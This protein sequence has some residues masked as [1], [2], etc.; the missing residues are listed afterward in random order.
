MCGIAGQ[1]A[2]EADRCVDDELVRR[3]VG[4]LVHRGPDGGGLFVD[5]D[6]RVAMGMRRLAIIDLVSG[7]QPVFNDDRSVVCVFNGEIYNFEELRS[8][9]ERRGHRLT[10][11]SD[12]EV[13]VHLYEEEGVEFV[14]RLRGMFAIALWD[15]RRHRF[16]LVRDR[17]GKKPLY[18]AE[19][20]GRLAFASEV[21]ALYD[22]P[23]LPK[24]V[25]P[26]ALDLYLT[27]SYVPSPHSIFRS[28]RKLPPAHR[29]VVEDGRVTVSRYWAL[30]APATVPA[31]REE[32]VS[33]VRA[34]L[35]EAVRLRMISDV[36]LGCFLSGGVDSSAVVALMSRASGKPVTTFSIGFTD[37]RVNELP[38]ARE[39]AR[40]YG[41]E[42]HEYV[43]KTDVREALPALARHFGEPYGDSSA[44][45]TWYVSKL[46]RQ[47]VTV[48]LNGDGGDELF[49][50]YTWYR[51][52]LTLDRLA[53]WWPGRGLGE[54]LPD[55]RLR[56]T[57]RR[58]EM[59]RGE[60]FASL[61][62]FLDPA[63]K[64]RLYAPALVRDV[65][66]ATAERYLADRYDGA[67]GDALAR[68]QHT[69]LATYLPEDL[70][71]K[72]DRMTMA[73]SL[74]GRSPLLDHE[75]LECSMAIPSN[76]KVRGGM[77]KIIFREAIRDLFPD[78]FLDRPKMGFSAP[79]AEW[80]RGE[81]RPE[82][83][84]MLRHGPLVES[85]WLR[86]QAVREL[87]AEHMSGARDRSDQLWNL[88]ML[89]QW[90]GIYLS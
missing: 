65:G 84:R 12:S 35:E 53:A 32:L 20:A 30:P 33:R 38:W 14:R 90:A 46:A 70:L 31:S 68:M 72:V 82:C 43:V 19:T 67:S 4:A 50:G 39:V 15:R 56:R 9:L 71:V 3:M 49:G 79:I 78:G 41:T 66:V 80:L 75:L 69:D 27:Y 76:L 2:F 44:V 40:R 28:I 83:D 57:A 74:E 47:H 36:P 64:E 13:I 26:V 10:S 22:V 87:V 6:R 73:H 48:A 18:Y 34:K 55:G 37:Q 58:L 1:V 42:H 29:L 52:G 7:D 5:P 54:L 77:T 81:L 63:L 61:R 86:P 23:D 16:V 59:S 89:D 24:E 21:H 11:T 17:V 60:R 88:L 8:D 62:Q 51:S 45:P 25:D 85:G